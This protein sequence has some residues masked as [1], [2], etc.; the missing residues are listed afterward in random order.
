[1]LAFHNFGVAVSSLFM[2]ICISLPH[3]LTVL[4][5]ALLFFALVSHAV[6]SL[7]AT[8]QRIAL[9]K[10]WAIILVKQEINASLSGFILKLN[11]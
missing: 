4:R 8:G 10:D 2:A 1:M 11:N 7:A 5:A 3:E 6:S 9:T